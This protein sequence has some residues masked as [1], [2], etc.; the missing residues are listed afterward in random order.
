MDFLASNS[1]YKFFISA[2]TIY[3]SRFAVNTLCMY[4]QMSFPSSSSLSKR[5]FLFL[6]IMMIYLILF[7]LLNIK[8]SFLIF[9]SNFF[10]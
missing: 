1:W 10:F 6:L 7:L 4:D 2:F 5:V 9:S 3:F 8:S